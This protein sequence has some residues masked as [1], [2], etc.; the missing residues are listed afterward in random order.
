M[1]LRIGTRQSA[2]ALRQT[3]LVAA[4]LRTRFPQLDIDIVPMQT[5]GDKNLSA[6]LTAFGGK[7]AFV[8]EF[9]D[10]MLRGDIDATV[11]SAKDLPYALAD[12]LEVAMV[13]PREDERDVLVWQNRAAQ[14][15]ALRGAP[16]VIGTAS[17]RRALQLHALFPACTTTLLRGNVPTRLSKLAAGDY[18]AIVLAAAGLKRLGLWS[19]A[20]ATDG[21]TASD[22]A[23]VRPTPAVASENSAAAPAT[24]VEPVETSSGIAPAAFVLQPLSFA[25]MLPAGGQG[26]VAVECRASDR[27]TKTLLAACNDA[28]TYAR[29]VAERAVLAKLG[30]GCHEP[31]A[32]FSTLS[33]AHAGGASDC[34]MTL[35]LAEERAGA[36]HRTQVSAPI[37]DVRTVRFSVLESLADALLRGR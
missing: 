24:D 8:G 14:E 7:G 30:A 18:D 36:L 5:R 9:E 12:G 32:V 20:H 19:A 34:T 2:L 33:P 6:A 1:K 21:G 23:S 35:T 4:A 16:V 25:E 26:I 11:H 27:R 29:F 22:S 31:T 15:A 10:A 3:E 13:L 17:P 37:G 28:A